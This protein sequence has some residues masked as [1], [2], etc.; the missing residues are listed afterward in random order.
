[1]SRKIKRVRVNLDSKGIKHLPDEEI[2]IILRGA[3]ELIGTG[4]RN[5]LAKILK[6]SKEK[7]LLEL[8]LDKC[9]V[10]GKF[11]SEKID[12]VKA[13]IDWLIE[14]YYLKIEYDYKIPVLLFTE[15]GWEI[16]KN[17][18]ADEIIEEFNKM[19]ESGAKSF[20]MDYLKDRNR[21]MILLI[22]EKI[23]KTKNLKY[24]PI[25]ESWEKIDYKKVRQEIRKT[26]NFLKL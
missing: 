17:T 19:L 3:D 24:I 2:K 26:I 9:P 21:G 23:R 10:Y 8:S 22:L 14:N 18:Y 4:G 11:K 20:K 1:M 6:G 15:K 25:L 13:K 12:D 16:E 5:M 7:K